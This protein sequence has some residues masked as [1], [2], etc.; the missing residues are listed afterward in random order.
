MKKLVTRHSLLITCLVLATAMLTLSGCALNCPKITADTQTAGTFALARVPA[1]VRPTVANY[2]DVAAAGLRSINGTPTVQALINQVLSFIPQNVLT[3]YPQ[4]P[5][6][7]NGVITF[8]Y[9]TY[10]QQGLN[11]AAT[12]IENSAAPYI[13]PPHT[14]SP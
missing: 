3:Q 9:Q 8:A 7:L 6:A 13:S 4:I 11:C 2:Y 14:I 5:I 10:G 12:G 1:S